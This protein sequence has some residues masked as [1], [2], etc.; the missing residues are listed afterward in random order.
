MKVY[1]QLF[2][3]GLLT[4][5]GVTRAHDVFLPVAGSAG[6]F[7]SDVR[8]FNPSQT[9]D[10]EVR[11]YYLATGN[12]SNAN[13]SSIAITVPR[14]RMAIYNDVVASLFHSSGLGGI[15]LTSSDDFVVTE[16]VYATSTTACSGAVN[17]CTLGQFVQGID[18][19]MA[20]TGGVLLQ[21]SAPTNGVPASR[22]NIGVVNTTGQT[23]TVTWRVYDRNN[24]LTGTP[25]VIQMPAYAV[26]APSDLRTFGTTIP[27]SADL[28]DAWLSFVSDQPLVAYASVVDNG[29]TDQT[30]IPAVADSDP[31]SGD[32]APPVNFTGTFSGRTCAGTSFPCE[33]GSTVN[34]TLN[35]TQTGSTI[36]GNGSI[37]YESLQ[38]A[39]AVLITGSV[40]GS[41]LTLKLTDNGGGCPRQFD[42]VVTASTLN[43][44]SG[45]YVKRGG[46]NATTVSG[47][48]ALARVT[49]PSGPVVLVNGQARSG[50]S[51]GAGASAAYTI[52]VPGDRDNLTIETFGG[53]GD[54]DLYLR[55][56]SQPTPTSYTYSSNGASTIEKISINSD[57]FD[58][59]DVLAGDWYITVYGYASSS[60]VSVKATYH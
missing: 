33:I 27:A 29:S 31:P 42:H 47:T 8:I 53:S 14:R 12:V 7:R 28:S 22:T 11:G 16:R 52:H 26:L 54:V 24:T 58:L 50:I 6:V 55:R 39:A 15:R 17:P 3:C 30:C 25:K 44:I 34:S 9:K 37:F 57:I 60:G 45:A 32:V 20:L 10:I 40:N 49:A 48:F 38:P 56:G 2:F 41:T 1:R 46:C 21:L 18:S 19:S 51:L 23:A 5:A 59:E 36:S 4:V 43:A 13:V 35:L